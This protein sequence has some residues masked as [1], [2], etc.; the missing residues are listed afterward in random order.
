[1]TQNTSKLVTFGEAMVRLSPPEFRRLEQAHTLDFQAGGAELNAAIAAHR[2]G[3]PAR[4]V[5]RLTQNPLGHMIENKAREHGVDTSCIAWTDADRVGVYFVEFGAAPRPNTVLYDRRDS[6]MA[7]VRLGEID[8]ECALRGAD[9]FHTSGITPALSP[10]AAAETIEAIR[11]ARRLGAQV[12]V[13]LNYRARLWTQAEARRVMSQIASETDI[14]ITTEEDTERVFG[15]AAPSYEEVARL[16]AREFALDAVVITLRETPSVWRN[17]WSAMA[18]DARA[19]VVI[20]APTFDIEVVDRVGSGDAFAGGFLAGY[21]KDGIELGVRWGVGV[22]ALKQ[23]Y[24]WDFSC[25]T[26]ED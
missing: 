26:P 12:S 20:H 6:A 18:Y 10:S 23:T 19:D 4:F 25:A 22:S 8:W 7:H 1:M 3:L 13:D 14:L 2:L 9:Y 24:P 16:L 21:A 17:A 11:T 15:I 5:T